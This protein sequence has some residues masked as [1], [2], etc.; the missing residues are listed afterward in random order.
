MENTS[1][2]SENSSSD[3]ISELEK[4]EN[5]SPKLI[6]FQD[7]LL[8]FRRKQIYLISK[9]FLA[10]TLAFLYFILQDPKRIIET[11]GS[12]Q[13]K[14]SALFFFVSLC[15]GI[16]FSMDA[17]IMESLENSERLKTIL[18]TKQLLNQNT[19]APGSRD[20]SK[21]VNFRTLFCESFN[22]MSLLLEGTGGFLLQLGAFIVGAGILFVTFLYL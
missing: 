9:W 5:L 12:Y 8:N 18:K 19:T 21:E 14:I 22:G 2:N 10:G 1:N 6:G 20:K 3:L 4:I 11:Y 16:Y 15:S 17:G 7:I 13:A